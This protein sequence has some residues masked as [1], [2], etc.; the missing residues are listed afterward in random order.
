METE[1]T[2]E[3]QRAAY[4]LAVVDTVRQQAPKS[5]GEYTTL[6][7]AFPT[8]ILAS[9]LGQALAFLMTKRSK[10]PAH[11][12]LLRHLNGWMCHENKHSPYFCTQKEDLLRA[13]VA[14]TQDQYAVAQAEVIA[15]L[16]WIKRCA[17]AYLEAGT[18]G[19]A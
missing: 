4:A 11:D 1:R 7:A 14:G 10:E 5:A 6:S 18:R 13:V 2:L 9:G 8:L 19:G 17:R 16:G 15:L 3:Q 12:L